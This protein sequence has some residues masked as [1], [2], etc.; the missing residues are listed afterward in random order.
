MCSYR[1]QLLHLAF[2]ILH[3]ILCSCVCVFMCSYRSQ[4]LHLAFCILHFTFHI[5]FMCLCVHVF[6]SL[7]TF[8]FCGFTFYILRFYTS[9]VQNHIHH[10][11]HKN[12]SSDNLGVPPPPAEMWRTLKVCYIYGR[13]KAGSGYPLS[14]RPNAK[15]NP[16]RHTA[17]ILH[18]PYVSKSSKRFLCSN[19]RGD[20]TPSYFHFFY[21]SFFTIIPERTDIVPNTD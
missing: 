17:P 19:F 13:A 2:Y 4:L 6:L 21:S 15:A 18:A 16:Q 9:N 11:D 3:F 20:F 5:V 14:Y 10:N 1:S 8:T 7:A 12:H